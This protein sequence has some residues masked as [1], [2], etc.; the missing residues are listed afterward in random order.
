MKRIEKAKTT[1]QNRHG[2]RDKQHWASITLGIII[3]SSISS[4]SID[5]LEKEGVLEIRKN[6]KDFIML[7]TEDF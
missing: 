7:L 1:Y 3:S 4:K 2:I 5:I 6:V